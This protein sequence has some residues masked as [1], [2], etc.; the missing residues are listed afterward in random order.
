MKFLVSMLTFVFSPLL[1]AQT[2]PSDPNDAAAGAA[3]LA[4]CGGS[5]V[6]IVAIF[7]LNIALLVWVARDAKSRG[8]DGAV[9]WMLLVMFTSVI[10]LIIYL[11]ARPQGMLIQCPHCTNKRLHASAKCPHCGHS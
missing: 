7:V 6:F 8:M 3:G 1:L 4:C 2:S 5:L 10:G 11:C 9:L